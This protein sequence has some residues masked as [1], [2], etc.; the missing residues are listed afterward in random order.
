VLSAYTVERVRA[1]ESSVMATLPEGELMA[2]AARGLAEVCRARLSGSPGASVVALVGPGN[3]GAD[4]LYAA[5]HLA[6]EGFDCTALQGDWSLP[7]G[8][9]GSWEAAGVRV[10]DTTG[11]WAAALDAADLV[12]DGVLG[13]GG[14]PGL[15]APAGEWIQGIPES[16]YVVSVDLPSGQDPQGQLPSDQGVFADETVT[17]G[18]AKPVHLLPATE[19]AV[20]RLTVVDIG[21]TVEG[22]ADVERLDF[23]DVA[24]LWPVPGPVDDKYSRGVLGVVAGGEDFTGAAVLCC[25]AAV[26][27]GL[28]M[29]RYVGTATPVGLVRS[30]VPEAVIGAGRVQAWVVGPG[31]D[32]ASRAAGSRT[33]LD[34]ARGALASDQPVLVDA[35]GLDLVTGRRNGPTLLTPHAGELAR[36]LSRVT[37]EDVSR[38]DVEVAPVDAARRA[39]DHTGA[40]VLLKGSTTLVVPPTASGLPV[41]S[42]N[43]APPWLATAGSGDVLAGLCGA[44]LA[45]GLSP[46]DAASLGALVHGVAAD[47]AN[48]GGPLRALAVAHGIP[49][50]VAELLN[51]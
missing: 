43:D 10:V 34:V 12:V 39:A 30:A 37:G 17:F 23:D 29:L 22:P 15:P 18:V 11:D 7:A 13:I 42:Q 47:R 24:R 1:A 50:T 8:D 51:R 26:G 27:A 16:A 2:R 41:R 28:G 45:A 20:G 5:A 9:R 33:Q 38:A 14:R 19:L 35:G 36:L 32:T 4:A 48:P 31:L 21:L 49:S 44:L 46:L 6:D 40:T 25:T 3:N